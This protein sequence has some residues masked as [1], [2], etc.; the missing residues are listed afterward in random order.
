MNQTAQRMSSSSSTGK[1]QT[2]ESLTAMDILDSI[3]K[4]NEMHMCN[5]YDESTYIEMTKGAL[6]KS[7]FA[8]A[9]D[10]RGT[11]YEMIMVPESSRS[12]AGKDEF[13]VN[14]VTAD[15]EPLYME[16]SQLHSSIKTLTKKDSKGGLN[17][18]S[19]KK[20]E[21]LDVKSV[22]T[23]KKQNLES[24]AELGGEK[25]NTMGRMK[26]AVTSSSSGTSNVNKKKKKDKNWP[27]IVMQ[28]SKSDSES[29]SDS[30]DKLNDEC[31]R[32]KKK[33]HG[34]EKKISS[35]TADL[36]S[37]TMARSRF[38]L[39][40]TFRP[41]S[42]YLGASGS[43]TTPFSHGNSA[44]ESSFD[45]L[46]DSS[47]SDIVSPP[48]I[49][50]TSLPLDEPDGG[51]VDD[52]RMLL[53]TVDM[54][55][56]A[57]R[58]KFRSSEAID[59]IKNHHHAQEKR[60]SV[61]SLIT[62]TSS[63]GQSLAGSMNLSY[64]MRRESGSISSNRSSLRSSSQGLFTV[65]N[66]G[67]VGKQTRDS[68]GGHDRC[69]DGVSHASSEYELLVRGDACASGSRL[70]S[71]MESARKDNSSARSSITLSE[72]S[73][74][75][76]W[77]SRSC[78]DVS[79]RNKRRPISGSSIN[80]PIEMALDGIDGSAE[81]AGIETDSNR[82]NRYLSQANIEQGQAAIAESN[83]GELNSNSSNFSQ[84][85]HDNS[86]Y[87]EN[88]ELTGSNVSE[89]TL[90]NLAG[91][92]LSPLREKNLSLHDA[93]CQSEYLSTV[94]E[95]NSLDV[96]N[97]SLSS[98]MDPDQQSSCTIRYDYDRSNQCN[99]TITPIDVGLH[100]VATETIHSRNN[101]TL[102]SDVAPY[103]YSDLQAARTREEESIQYQ[104]G[105]ESAQTSPSASFAGGDTLNNQRDP[106]ALRKHTTGSIFHIHNPLN[107]LKTANLLLHAS[108]NE[109]HA[110]IDRKNIYESDRIGQKDVNKTIAASLAAGGGGK[111]VGLPAEDTLWRDNL[112]RVSH[113][114]AKS[115]DNLDHLGTI[116]SAPSA[117]LLAKTINQQHQQ[118]QR[119]MLQERFCDGQQV[120]INSEEVVNRKPTVKIHRKDVTYVN[121][122]QT[123]LPVSKAAL[124]EPISMGTLKKSILRT[125]TA[126][127]SSETQS[128]LTRAVLCHEG[129]ERGDGCNGD[130]DDVYVQLASNV[131]SSGTIVRDGRW[132][133]SSGR[134]SDAVYEVLRDEIN[135]YDINRETIR[136]WDLMSSGLVNSSST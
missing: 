4:S 49:P 7:V 104:H 34:K 25:T 70:G 23:K 101:S 88:V 3:Q 92:I 90:R 117:A 100:S 33:L 59:L 10:L 52:G 119:D 107:T 32:I 48:P 114:H 129:S 94:L 58:E 135:R 57:N 128:R 40:D 13:G 124:G 5:A 134:E 130:D 75:I 112:R 67:A 133:S 46:L 26:N 20:D 77:R 76:E 64:G 79:V 8:T 87:Y 28:S 55:R 125:P 9:E 126:N 72:T 121:E 24:A 74:S 113:I 136:Q 131:S 120:E 51:C 53:G 19:G 95:G 108:A 82:C 41:A 29:E 66:S 122:H 116:R 2:C 80:C 96:E 127:S 6:G 62:G 61:Q 54:Q 56:Y 12:L 21:K 91:P 17:S 111:I 68:L 99:R 98:A 81:M 42:Y 109:K 35:H 102:S 103:Y 78:M 110:E 22:E 73:G 84:N 132:S 45:I 31:K 43:T 36:Q 60:Q 18:G 123:N 11:T 83:T 85:G 63:G 27:D 44:G 115:M 69:Y 30:P 47:D 39:S 14:R 1:L 37:K 86:I 93:R 71:A 38:S 105:N 16:L 50:I 65:G 15:S 118:E 106:G 89:L 97:A